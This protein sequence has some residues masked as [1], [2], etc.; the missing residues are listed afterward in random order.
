MHMVQTAHLGRE[1]VKFRWT[2][3]IQENSGGYWGLGDDLKKTG[4]FIL[5]SEGS[6]VWS[7]ELELVET[8]LNVT[9]SVLMTSESHSWE[10]T[11]I[12]SSVMRDKNDNKFKRL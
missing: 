8:R 11:L 5:P 3:K 6:H 1:H 9:W 4:E 7:C 2:C 10:V 12:S